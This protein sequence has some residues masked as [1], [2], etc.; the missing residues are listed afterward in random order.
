MGGEG[1]DDLVRRGVLGAQLGELPRQ[2]Y[3]GREWI[4]LGEG[5]GLGALSHAAVQ[6][7]REVPAPAELGGDLGG[8]VAELGALPGR[9]VP[10]LGDG[11]VDALGRR[12]VAHA[13]QQPPEVRDQAAGEGRVRIHAVDQRRDAL[14]IA[15]AAEALHPVAPEIEALHLRHGRDHAGGDDDGREPVHA[16]GQHRLV[17]GG[18]LAR[19]TVIGRVHQSQ[20]LH[21]DGRVARDIAGQVVQIGLRNG[22]LLDEAADH[23]R[24]ARDAVDLIEQPVDGVGHGEFYPCGGSRAQ[25][26]VRRRATPGPT[27]AGQTLVSAPSARSL[28]IGPV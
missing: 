15:R 21:G 14:G 3:H 9:P 2:M 22:Q 26:A 19:Q 7:L 16:E 23:V 28:G 12:G 11:A 17:D 1:T 24:H 10:T 4:E 6:F 13:Q 27:A 20:D 18:E 8:A 5:E 25:P